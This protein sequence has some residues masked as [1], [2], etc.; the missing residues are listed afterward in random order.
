MATGS[1]AKESEAHK[2]SVR[3]SATWAGTLSLI[4][5]NLVLAVAVSSL[6][7]NK[8]S[9][10]CLGFLSQEIAK[11]PKSEIIRAILRVIL[12]RMV[13]N[14]SKKIKIYMYISVF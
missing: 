9:C 10:G 6:I 14:W 11:I 13:L 12:F 2:V 3:P 7:T 4:S 1:G 5:L 8:G